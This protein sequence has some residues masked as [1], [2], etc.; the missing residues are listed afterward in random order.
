MTKAIGKRWRGAV[1]GDKTF[2]LG[3]IEDHTYGLITYQCPLLIGQAGGNEVGRNVHQ[4]RFDADGGADDAK[5]LVPGQHFIRCNVKSMS[6]GLRVAEQAY[7]SFGEISVVRDHPEGR[8]VSRHDHLLSADHPV[9]GGIRL[10][11]AIEHQRNQ[12]FA[13]G[14]RWPHYGYG[15]ALVAI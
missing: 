6:D 12:G 13:I 11:P 10:L 15:K 8:A 14:E 4:L 3:V 1:A 5:E 7:E 9:D 2:N